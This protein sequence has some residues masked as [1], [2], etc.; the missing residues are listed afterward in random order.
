MPGFFVRGRPGRA[1][2]RKTRKAGDFPARKHGEPSVTGI[3][4]RI[5]FHLLY[6]WQ[7][8]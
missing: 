2:P 8:T 1:S 7:I 3:V 5:E 6:P 4:Q